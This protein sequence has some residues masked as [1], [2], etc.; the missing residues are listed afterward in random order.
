M[1]TVVTPASAFFSERMS[2]STPDLFVR[3]VT[4]ISSRSR[5]AT[6]TSPPS[7]VGSFFDIGRSGSEAMK[8]TQ[9]GVS[10][11]WG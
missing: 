6:S 10:R 4:P 9:K 5:R 7:I 8:S 3:S 1:I 2:D 11:K